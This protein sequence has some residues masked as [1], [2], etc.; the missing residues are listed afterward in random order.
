MKLIKLTQGKFAQVDDVDYDWLNQWKWCAY[1]AYLTYYAARVA[2]LNGKP[3]HISMHRLIM[4]TPDGLD[5]DHRNHNGL[6]N[7]R[8]NL[9][10]CTKSQNSC[11]HKS[12]KT[13]RYKGVYVYKTG[14]RKGK[15]KA[16]ICI[17]GKCIYLG[18]FKTKQLAAQAYNDAAKKYHGEF[19]FLNIKYS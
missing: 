14:Y 18:Y 16:Q 12:P 8:Q 19:A 15:I 5:C 6:D 3:K 1:K 11:N 10:N 2:P 7:R 9:R 13:L 17:K 4:N